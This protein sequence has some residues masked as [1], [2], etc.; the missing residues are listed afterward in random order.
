M[1]HL[2]SGEAVNALTLHLLKAYLGVEQRDWVATLKSARDEQEAAMLA[3]EA[4]PRAAK[5]STTRTPA[6]A[7]Y[8]GTYRDAWRGD[9][10][11]RQENGKLVL[12]FSRTQRMKGVLEPVSAGLFVV[13]WQD[14]SLE[15]DAYVRF[16]MGYEGDVEGMTMRAVSPRTDFSYDFHDLDFRK[17]KQ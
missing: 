15:A 13:R 9:A 7:V 2:Q 17:V 5:K 11:I 16:A 14:R 10:T 1:Q 12:A 3:L 8:V 6:D 4:K